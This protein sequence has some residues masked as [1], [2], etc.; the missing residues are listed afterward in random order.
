MKKKLLLLLLILLLSFNV[1]Y[2]IELKDV[3]YDTELGKI[4]SRMVDAGIINGYTDGTFR[5]NSPIL[6]SEFIKILNKTFAYTEKAKEVNFKDVDSQDW[7]YEDL[8]I[9]V[10][11]KYINGYDDGTFKPNK[12]ITREEFCKI[13]ASVLEVMDLPF[14]K[15]IS[16]EISEWAK[17]Y[18]NKIVSSRIMLLEVD[19]KFRAK[20]PITRGEVCTVLSNYIVAKSG[21]SGL[22]E[23]DGKD[24][25]EYNDAEDL[26]VKLT[27]VNNILLKHVMPE[28]L[29]ETQ[30]QICQMIYD[31]IE[32]YLKD[33]SYDY[34]SAANEAYKLYLTLSE[35]DKTSFQNIM[36]K[37]NTVGDLNEL[38]DFFFPK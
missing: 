28:L 25:G 8:L 38:K 19:N 10:E 6:R 26:A 3:D 24:K 12:H 4:I 36:L 33:M 13:L 5:A 37:H 7:Y 23:T 17:P 27:R 11:N 2:A 9:A 30:K 35:D 21:S 34:K 15:E 32:M 14:D 1:V 16:D 18:V 31:N 29:N 20:D 22:G